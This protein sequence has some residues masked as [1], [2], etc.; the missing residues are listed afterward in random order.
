MTNAQRDELLIS[1]AKGLNNLQESL[2]DTR[3]ELKAEIKQSAEDTKAILREE[4]KQSAEDTKATLRNEL[5]Q[6]IGY[7]RGEFTQSIGNLRSEFT[8]SI[9]NLRSEF[10]QALKNTEDKLI[11]KIEA[12]S[13]ATAKVFKD[14]RAY[15]L[16]KR[17]A[18]TNQIIELQKKI[19]M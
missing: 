6:S 10:T 19:D 1:M 11:D 12:E 4:I 17:Q 13:R 7:L 16:R 3:K 5:T 9:G 15:E 18:L 8:Q 14:H 2:N